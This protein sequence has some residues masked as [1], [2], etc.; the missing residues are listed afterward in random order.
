M[1]DS[2]SKDAAGAQGVGVTLRAKWGVKNSTSSPF[3]P[4]RRRTGL[5]VHTCFNLLHS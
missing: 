1:S 3:S 2:C 5:G 4:P